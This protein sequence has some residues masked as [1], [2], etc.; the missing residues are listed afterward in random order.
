M[1]HREVPYGDRTIQN[2]RL[3]PCIREGSEP[4]K[5]AYIEDFVSQDGCI[6]NNSVIWRRGN[7]IDAGEKA[8]NY[9]FESKIN[10]KEIEFIIEH[11]REERG[12][13]KS[14]SLSWGKLEELKL[15]TS[16]T[17]S[18]TADKIQKIITENRNRLIDD[19]AA[20]VKN[21]GVDIEVKASEI[22][23]YPKS[24]RVSVIWQAHTTGLKEAIKLGIITPPNDEIKEQKMREMIENNPLHTNEALKELEN[25]DIDFERWWE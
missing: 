8:E 5:R 16:E 24:G 19:E 11:G 12:N 23:H 1:M 9:K 10:I 13:A 25:G 3:I 14:T 15:S 22:K 2:P 4:V 20:I 17:L 7:V 18:D 6:G 21:L